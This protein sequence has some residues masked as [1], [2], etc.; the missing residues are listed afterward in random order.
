MRRGCSSFRG[1]EADSYNNERLCRLS[2]TL[3]PIRRHLRQAIGDWLSMV[4]RFVE[5]L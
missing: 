2:P 3:R 4:R 5:A 1:T